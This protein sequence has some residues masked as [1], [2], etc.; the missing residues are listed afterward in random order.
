MAYAYAGQWG[1]ESLINASG[2]PY[3][4]TAYSVLLTGTSTAATL[5]TD[6][7]KATGQANPGLS[8]DAKGNA[9][10]F[11]DPGSYD[12]SVSGTVVLTGVVVLPDRLEL[13][14]TVGGPGGVD[15]TSLVTT[16]ATAAGAGGT[17]TFGPGTYVV[18]GLAASVAS[19]HWVIPPGTTVKTKNAANTPTI[20]LTANGVTIDGGGTIDGNRVNQTSTTSG[21]Y[22]L[23]TTACVRVIGVSDATVRGLSL[24][25]GGSNGIYIDNASNVTVDACKVTGCCPAG[26]TKPINIFDRVGPCT[27][28]RVTGNTVDGVAQATGCIG[29]SAYN[30][31]TISQLRITGNRLLLGNGHATATL[32]VELFTSGTG[33][34]L[35]AT[36]GGNLIIGPAGVIASDQVFGISVGGTS[37]GTTTGESQVSVTGNVVRNCSVKSIEVIGRGVAVTGNTIVNSGALSVAAVQVPGGI[38][39]VSVTGNSISDCLDPNYTL[40]LDGGTNGIFGLVVSGNSIRNSAGPGIVTAGT[41]TGATISANTLSK[42]SGANIIL[43]GTF[44][45]STVSAN[46]LDLTSS[47]GSTNDG[48]LIGSAATARVGIS[49]NSIK[50][51][52]RYGIYGL[53]ATSDITIGANTIT[54]CNCGL[55]ADSTATRW[56]VVGNKIHNN[57][58]RGLIFNV[59]GVNLLIASNSIHDNPGGDYYTTGSTF[60]ANIINGAGG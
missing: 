55:R 42:V 32:G 35:D 21:D 20:D 48:V 24:V 19:Q 14:V 26:N 60:L 16:A 12:L 39:G 17:L 6:R 43:G 1:P 50:G 9:R 11:A 10:F 5:Y 34:I 2:V 40:N 38:V 13:N 56:T 59:A 27:N 29:V 8:T 23:G 53:A 7:T 47:T 18:S 45:D 28:I 37:T 30:A 44:T 22:S 25:N 52:S 3:V 57:T 54:T 58:S 33:V 4:N 41:I 31:R 36:V 49:G 15:D 46:V 51:A